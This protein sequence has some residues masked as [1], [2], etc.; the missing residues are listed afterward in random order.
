LSKASENYTNRCVSLNY[1]NNFD[2]INL[3]KKQITSDVIYGYLINF[4]N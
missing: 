4:I 3:K 1:L 2:F